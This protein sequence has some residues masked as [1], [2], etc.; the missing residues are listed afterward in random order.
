M[1]YNCLCIFR[2]GAIQFSFLSRMLFPCSRC[3]LSIREYRHSRFSLFQNSDSMSVRVICVSTSRYIRLGR[4]LEV[5]IRRYYVSRFLVGKGH[6]KGRGCPI[7]ILI[8]C[9]EQVFTIGSY[10]RAKLMA[11]GVDCIAHIC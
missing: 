11:R 1:P 7:N 5:T 2:F 3:H 4:T 10:K 8:A 9:I 6:K